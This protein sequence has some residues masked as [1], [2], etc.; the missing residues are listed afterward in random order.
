LENLEDPWYFGVGRII[1]VKWQE[2]IYE[3]YSDPPYEYGGFRFANLDLIDV[4]K[5]IPH[6]PNQLELSL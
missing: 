6:D 1:T 4:R 2:G 5:Y 3:V